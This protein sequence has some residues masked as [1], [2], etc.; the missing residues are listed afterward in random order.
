MSVENA[1][2][3]K[4]LHGRYHNILNNDENID[5]T[6]TLSW[7]TRG[8]IFPETEGFLCAIQDQIIPTRSYLKYIVKDGNIKT[9]K[10][11][12]CNK[13]HENVEHL[14][15]SCEVLAPRE[16][17]NRHN[18]VAKI[19]H[20]EICYKLKVI[21][22]KTPYYK[23]NPKN[24][25]ENNNFMVY[26]DRE[27]QTDREV[28]HNRPDILIFDKQ[29]KE[30]TI[31]DISVPA[32]ANIHKKEKEKI[33][34]YLLLSEDMK[35]TWQATCVR[36]IPIVIGATGEITKNLKRYLQ[37]LDQPFGIHTELQKAAILGTCNVVRKVLN[38]P[39]KEQEK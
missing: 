35:E 39:A 4:E 7:L 14:I 26:W 3:E 31:I 2:K 12:M 36:V 23:Y 30:I 22:C 29:T 18:N 6:A 37:V 15:S 8:G 21:D 38:K 27:I 16:Y 34:K 25:A 24:V 28:I 11:R 32:P 19:L 13:G 9:T 5:K 17:T 33:D 20:I 10:C 1:W